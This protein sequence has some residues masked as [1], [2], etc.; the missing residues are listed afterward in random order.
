MADGS[1]TQ[2]YYALRVYGTFSGEGGTGARWTAVR[3]KLLGEPSQ[4]AMSAWPD[5]AY[6][7]PCRDQPVDVQFS[8][9]ASEVVCGMTTG[10]LRSSDWS[11]IVTWSCTGCIWPDRA[12]RNVALYEFVAVAEG[13]VPN[14]EI[15][16]DVGT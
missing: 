12:S 8:R 16:A 9:I 5:G 15:F 13:T 7:G 3:A 6:D 2:D 11:V 4:G 10:A 1:P 14:W